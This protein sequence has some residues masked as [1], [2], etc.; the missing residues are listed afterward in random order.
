MPKV[1]VFTPTWVTASGEYAMRAEC[2]AAIWAQ[3]FD[4][5]LEYKVGT[6][7]PYPIG[8]HR[9]VTHQYQT[10]QGL[11]LAGDYDALVTVEHD[12]VLPDSGAIQRLYNSP[13]DVVY[14]VYQLRHNAQCLNTWQ[15]INDRNLGMSLSHYPDEL[16]RYRR[17]GI[18]RICG[19]GM[20]ATLFRR[21]ALHA[22]PFR[23][24]G[25]PDINFAEDALRAG[26]L[27]M[28]RFDVPVGHFDGD[29]LLDPYA[30]EE[31]MRVL[32]VETVNAIA[33]GAFVRLVAGEVYDL[34][35]RVAADLLRCG[36]IT[37]L[38]GEPE[39]AMMG[40]PEVAMMP[41]PK[42]KRVK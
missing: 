5:E 15:Y 6:D 17:D 42:S 36:Y 2:Q 35:P 1:L 14:G 23:G 30:T 27:S 32:A 28:G 12:N 22:I 41:K 3:E 18:G 21:N 39:T 24:E 10:A 4:G 19:C 33:G 7:N 11:L 40:T 38:P 20:G 13:G 31:K 34:L 8:E 16:A 9:N 26:L 29:V 25:A 37:S